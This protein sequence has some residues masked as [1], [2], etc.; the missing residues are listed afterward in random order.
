[1][2]MQLKKELKEVGKNIVEPAKKVS[3]MGEEVVKTI[4]RPFIQDKRKLTLGQKTADALTKWGGSWVFILGFLLFLILWIMANIYAW[5]NA[6]DTYPFI[7]LNLVLSCLAAI[8]APVILMSQNRANQRDRL[9]ADYDYD[10]NRKAEREIQD[11]L[12]QLN[13]IEKKMK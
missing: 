6:W 10:V 12:K 11:I 8:Q 7:L 3:E 2:K 9:R 4:S 13:R 5:V 1:M